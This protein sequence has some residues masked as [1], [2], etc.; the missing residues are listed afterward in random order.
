MSI[1]IRETVTR[2]VDP[3]PLPPEGRLVLTLHEWEPGHWTG[4][5][6]DQRGPIPHRSIASGTGP[7]PEGARAAALD[8][9]ASLGRAIGAVR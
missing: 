7:T 8:D 1:A 3:E 4:Y 6:C 9:L 5:V 2:K